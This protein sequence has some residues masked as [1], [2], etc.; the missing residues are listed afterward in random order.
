MVALGCMVLAAAV[1]VVSILARHM[2][3]E[4]LVAVMAEA[5]AL[6]AATELPTLAAV[7]AV[8]AS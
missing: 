7:V 2:V 8:V 1:V 4:V 5:L 6:Q 3:L